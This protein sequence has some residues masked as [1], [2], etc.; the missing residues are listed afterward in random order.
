MTSTLL[1]FFF[2]PVKDYPKSFPSIEIIIGFIYQLFSLKITGL[3][4]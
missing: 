1:I 3:K 4:K 2:P